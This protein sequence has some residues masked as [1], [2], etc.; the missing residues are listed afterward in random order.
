MEVAPTSRLSSLAWRNLGTRKARTFLT[1]LG[2]AL[3][4]AVILATAIANQSTIQA[5]QVMIDAITGKADFWIN[6]SSS[7]GFDQ[8][9]LADVA[10]TPGVAVANPGIARGSVL[11]FGRRHPQIQVAGIDPYLDRRLRRYRLA[12]GRFLRPSEF[13][14][15]TTERFARDNGAGLGDRI[16]LSGA[17]HR[18]RLKIVGLLRNEGA[19]RFM[20]GKIVFV[21]LKT[22]QKIFDMP[23]RLTYIDAKADE[24]RSL[25]AVADKIGRKL[26]DGFVI[27]QPEKR[28]EAITQMLKGLRVGLTFFGAIAMFVGGFLVYNTFAMVVLEQTRE[29]GTLRSLGAARRQITGLVLAQAAGVGLVGSMIGVGAGVWLARF[30]LRYVSKTV[31]LAIDELAIPPIGLGLAFLIGVAVTLASAMQP[32]MLAGSVSPLAAIK[33]HAKARSKR[34]AALRVTLGLAGLGAGVAVSLLPGENGLGNYAYLAVPLHSGGNF[35]YFLGAALLSPSLVGPLGALF[36]LPVRLFFGQTGKLAAANLRRNP[37]RTAATVSAIMITMAMLMSVGGMTSSFKKSVDRWVDKSLGADVFVSGRS[38][39]VSFNKDFGVKLR[40]IKGVRDMTTIRFIMVREAGRRVVWR[41]IDP[42]SF[43]R[44]ASLQFAEGDNRRAWKL[45]SRGRHVFISTVMANKRRLK[46]GDRITLATIKGP[47]KFK[48]A[49]VTVDFG[50]E[51]GDL[52]IGRRRDTKEYFGVD[53]V[54][55]FRIKTG[56][57]V[58]PRVV[59]D[60]IRKKY[61]RLDLEVQ[62]IQE[63]KDMADNQV[64]N[65]FAVFNVLIILAAIVAMISVFNTLMMSILER[66]REVGLLR[67]VGATRGQ[68]GLMTVLEAFITGAVGIFLGLIVGGYA[69]SDIVTGMKNLT[70]YEVGYVFPLDMTSAAV[71]IG[72]I[73]SV[74]AAVYPARRAASTEI[75]EALQYE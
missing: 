44:F 24:G 60:R 45:L 71:A 59:A 49:A 25:T 40:R 63:F 6:S 16:S 1:V 70:G 41:S 47:K 64:N 30:L 12:S 58:R 37:G 2:V 23:N 29:L 75:G 18:W 38:S 56:A 67:A 15:L 61:N 35:V 55:T 22:A 27:E 3:G 48:V 33:I 5:F 69:S 72:L 4:V 74:A 26:G 36:S 46:V 20:A 10:A 7:T 31:D 57:G 50:G 62:D 53:D 39:D 11:R 21:P 34:A 17:G 8:K 19:G 73:F 32:A 9:R 28:V 65:S 54:S 13:G 43:Q 66:Q 42:R 51:M 14:V 68:I 52:I